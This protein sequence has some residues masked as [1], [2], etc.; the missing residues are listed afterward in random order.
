MDLDDKI[1]FTT[2]NLYLREVD[3][4]TSMAGAGTTF[5][6]KVIDAIGNSMYFFK[7]TLQQSIIIIIYL[8]PFIV[9]LGV[10]G[11]FFYINLRINIGRIDKDKC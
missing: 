11:S 10:I 4:I 8:L 9:I 5:G 2:I 1:D 6:T 3:K 7:N